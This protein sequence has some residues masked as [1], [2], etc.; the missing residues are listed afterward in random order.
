MAAQTK[1]INNLTLS[2]NN[3]AV[4]RDVNTPL[5][6]KEWIVG[7]PNIIPG[8]E[9]GQYN[10]Y[11][12][13]WYRNK[14]KENAAFDSNI[15]IN[16]ILLLRQ[17]QLFFS[18]DEIE[19]WYQLVDFNNEKELLTAIPYFAKKLKE[20]A[21]HYINLREEIKKTK[22]KYNLIGT[23]TG[24]IQQLQE[25]LLTTFT[26]KSNPEV[27]VPASL[28]GHIPELSSIKDDLVIEVEEFYDDHSYFDRDP[29][30]SATIYFDVTS[31][32]VQ[33]YFT[34]KNYP[35][36]ATDWIYKLGSFQNQ[37][38][39]EN[40]VVESLNLAEQ[41]LTKY[42]AEDKFTGVNLVDSISASTTVYD[43][44]IES[45]NN[46][47][48]WPY[49]PY[50][51]TVLDQE[52]IKPI[53]LSS[54]VPD[55]ATA[56]AT[57]ETADTIFVKT[58]KGVT[59]AWLQYKGTDN[60]PD[61]LVAYIESNT[62]TAFKFPFPGFG[63]SADDIE[64]TGPSIRYSSDFFYLDTEYKKAVENAYWTFSNAQTGVEPIQLN[65]T[66]LILNG[67]YSNEKFALADKIRVWPEAPA[68]ADSSYRGS[69]DEAWLYKMSNTDLP[70]A[71]NLNNYLLWPY[72][73]I[74]PNEPLPDVIPKD[75]YT[76]CQ[77][78]LLSGMFLPFATGST[79][80]STS[81]IIFKLPNY[82]STLNEATECAW[83]S[84]RPEVFTLS[85]TFSGLSSSVTLAKV[86]QR[87]LNILCEAGD[88]TYFIWEGENNKDADE[89]F[90]TYQHQPDCTYRNLLSGSYLDFKLCTCQMTRFT[91][92]GHPGSR[93]TDYAGLADFIAEYRK[94]DQPFDITTWKDQYN[95][96]FIASSAA[97]FYRTRHGKID[98]GHGSWYTGTSQ[99]SNKLLLQT[100]KP[101]V[102]YR[103]PGNTLDP[104]EG[105]LP[106]LAVRYQYQNSNT[107]GV[108][109]KGVKSLNNVT[110]QQQWISLNEPSDMVISPGNI[111][112]Y[113]KVAG[114]TFYVTSAIQVQKAYASNEGS[115]WSNYDFVSLVPDEITGNI[116]LVI[117]SYP[118]SVF[119]NVSA[120]N[121][122]DPYKQYPII[123]I[124][125]FYRQVVDIDLKGSLSSLNLAQNNLQWVLVDP[126]K[127]VYN[128]YGTTTF[129]FYPTITGIYTVAFAAI[130]STQISRVS[131]TQTPIVTAGRIG[132]IWSNYDFISFD[133][134]QPAS[135]PE[136]TVT[137]PTANYAD[138]EAL[139]QL[140]EYRQYPQYNRSKIVAASPG[141]GESTVR[142]TIT[143]PPIGVLPPVELVADNATDPNVDLSYGFTPATLGLYNV[144]V[145]VMIADDPT[146]PFA[147]K[148]IPDPNSSNPNDTITVPTTSYYTFSNIPP[149]TAA[150]VTQATL[151]STNT[152]PTTGFYIFTNIPPITAT[153]YATTTTI[154]CS[155]I[156]P[157]PG[158]VLNAPLYGWNYNTGRL[159]VNG[160]GGKPFWAKSFNDKGVYTNF[161]GINSWGQPF[162]VIDDY[163]IIT[164]PFFSDIVLRSGSY[165][166]YERLYNS[167]F[168]W[169]QP[170][171]FQTT[172]DK[173]FW[174]TIV[175][176]TTATSNLDEIITN[177]SYELITIPTT[178]IS[179]IVLENFVDNM[180][181]EIYYHAI[182]PFVWSITASNN[183][184]T[185]APATVSAALVIESDRPWNSLT[186]RF[187]PTVAAFPTTESLYTKEDQGG[188]FTPK[189]LGASV[190]INKDYSLV[191]STSSDSLTSIFEDGTKHVGGRGLTKK[192]QPTP[193][194]T[195]RDNNMWLK[196]PVVSG[197]ISGTIKKQITKKYQ[198]FIPYQSAYET[199]S[200]TSLGLI[201]P[202][203][204]QD[205]WD[206][207]TD[208]DWG[209]TTNQPTNFTGVI[210][211]SAWAD[212]QLLKQTNKLLYN[213]VT[214]IYGNQYGLYKE[215]SSA[216]IY[217]RR[218]LP[219][220]IWVRKNSQLVLAGK[221][222]LSAVFD[223][224]KNTN[225]INDLTGNGVIQINM[226]FDTLYVQ[227]TGAV[228][229]EKIIYDYEEDR[230]F[231]ITD[232]ARYLSLAIPVSS[233]LIREYTLSS[234]SAFKFAVPG[235][236]WF[237]PEEKIVYL[238]VCGLSGSHLLPAIYKLDLNTRNLSKEFPTLA[239][240]TTIIA[241]TSSLNLSCVEPPVISYLPIKKKF[242]MSV[243][244]KDYNN[245]DNIIE[246]TIKNGTSMI[247]LSTT[248]YTPATSVPAYEV[249]PYITSSL[250][251]SVSSGASFSYKLSTQN[252]SA[253]FI[254]TNISPTWY[255]LTNTGTLSGIA[256]L[257]AGINFIPFLLTNNADTVYYSYTLQVTA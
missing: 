181:V 237:L 228:I 170:C 32:N 44:S 235:E 141:P 192:D 84:S 119:T 172:I 226:F 140:D 214:D 42:I 26:K 191:L 186:N 90:K 53:A 148:V 5:S 40:E 142:W 249:P 14:N 4:K 31:S 7:Y 236:T 196:E 69:T 137:Y 152:R 20:V 9:Y 195:P 158:F 36:S 218:N 88:Y 3:K 135:I 63:L 115:I 120:L 179:P 59:G 171:V 210:K 132:T 197:P 193:Y 118:A 113:N 51:S 232:D 17:L 138:P 71:P 87:G 238:S 22:L 208:T 121:A 250:Y 155:F 251:S 178:A 256:P 124:S 213:W 206:G 154:L 78:M 144:E 30:L 15:R 46:F 74:N 227:T 38:I 57:I 80:M 25:Q 1:Q 48:Y 194:I 169:T 230:I 174:N 201:T 125:D 222:A 66:S 79:D 198:K 83:L 27:T 151:S 65:D 52:R 19:K 92:F 143:S 253:T 24:V 109:I 255:T 85:T 12:L 234:L 176:E 211:I 10:T 202:T 215:I 129:S 240:S 231:S 76:V 166:E 183:I 157:S 60:R 123:R 11:L 221:D 168:I 212:T 164:Q 104:E 139:N 233:Q 47:F 70:V 107:S 21:L 243:L 156:T 67:A 93:Q 153:N 112:V 72:F 177:P 200:K 252:L 114:T 199:N 54:I 229:F 103:A 241:G 43:V 94:P 184:P 68:F 160:I 33:D 127:N 73:R 37:N 2:A 188:F 89:V 34:S 165:F 190:Y 223:T 136:V 205:P 122:N 147:V 175:F 159:E 257:S 203:S 134:N 64:W 207:P 128:F 189:Y 55:G 248:I 61:N 225:L 95:T 77:P 146:R 102:Y 239:E 217:Q 49:G 101:Y 16:Y 242:V 75:I 105:Q 173:K 126:N 185:Y 247:L 58:A 167:P 117:V 162:R 145:R 161:K 50:K 29:S 97:A 133:I 100:N 182:T 245:Y 254:S 149:I 111:L 246:M 131:L 98:W 91:P 219:G 116:P 150:N 35:L 96:S 18:R 224:Y 39:T 13:E 110:G 23:N 187:Y 86:E 220:D 106:G 209:D 6:F 41:I 28:W 81:D 130:T 99:N 216:N 56:G 108:W 8:Q 204:R 45:G 62:K 82:K 244:A 180:P 163:N